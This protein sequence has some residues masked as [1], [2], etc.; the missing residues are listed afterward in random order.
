M[1]KL[2]INTDG[3]SRGNPGIGASAFVVSDEDKKVVF[4]KGEFLEQTTNNKAEY[5]GVQMAME[6]L[7]T[8]G[9]KLSISSVEFFID[10]ELVVKQLNGIYKVKDQNL[11]KYVSVIQKIKRELNFKVS[12]TH[13]RREKNKVADLL[14]N[15]TMDAHI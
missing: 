4:E 6:W 15:S 5:R 9:K 11:A 10:S 3:G 1:S 2:T 13:V 12:F 8:E 7:S 14:V